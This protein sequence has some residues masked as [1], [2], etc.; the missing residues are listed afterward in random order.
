MDRKRIPWLYITLLGFMLLLLFILIFA[1]QPAISKLSPSAY[2]FLLVICDLA[3][4]AFLTGAMKSAASY[5]GKV[6]HG[7]LKLAGPPVVFFLILLIGYRYRPV[8]EGHPFDLTIFV[9]HAT[10]DP[11]RIA[12]V[13]RVHVKNDIKSAVL[14][15]DGRAIFTNINPEYLGRP[16]AVTAEIEGYRISRSNDTT[17]TIPDE[18]LPVVRLKLYPMADSV[19]YTGFIL[20]HNREPVAD[21]VVNFIEHV[22]NA[23]TD[24]NGMFKVYLPAKPGDRTDI[25]VFEAG[26][27]QYSDRI[28]LG[29]NI[30][31]SL[32]D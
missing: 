24:E 4:T 8:K 3:A 6:M 22:R 23:R 17:V 10:A 30:K 14:D 29:K 16:I 1:R 28:Y 27:L 21:A 11:A 26:I 31:I 7:T 32:D 2:F 9:S 19:L 13:L 5:I 15:K 20:R 12:G 25:M 18:S